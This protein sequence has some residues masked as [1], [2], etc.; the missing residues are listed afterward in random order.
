MQRVVWS[1]WASWL[2]QQRCWLV[3]AKVPIPRC[4][5]HYQHALMRAQR[6]ERWDGEASTCG[7]TMAAWSRRGLRP[8]RLHC[9]RGSREVDTMVDG[10]AVPLGL[11]LEP[12]GTRPLHL[13]EETSA[14]QRRGTWL[15]AALR[16][17]TRPCPT[18]SCC[19]LPS[20]CDAYLRPPPPRRPLPHQTLNQNSP[21]LP[22]S[23]QAPLSASPPGPQLSGCR[24]QLCPQLVLGP[25]WPVA[26]P[27]SVGRQGGGERPLAIAARRPAPK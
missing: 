4:W 11:A 7:S 6:P 18:P 23:Q 5:D 12:L 24:P 26:P 3:E 20:T 16:V 13:A 8:R 14:A 27:P 21:R 1:C 15:L 10:H 19:M 17:H 2:P 9:W 25:A 22:P